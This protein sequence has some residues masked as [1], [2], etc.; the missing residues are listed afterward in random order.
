MTTVD[1]TLDQWS[2]A[3]LPRSAT[4][5]GGAFRHR[6]GDGQYEVWGSGSVS[7]LAG[8]AHSIA[9]E[10]VNPVHYLQR[11]DDSRLDTTRTA[12][13]GDQE[14]LAVGKYGGAFTFEAAYERQSRG[15]DTND[16]G[17][18]QRADEQTFEGWIGYTDR[19][20][21]GFYKTWWANLN[22][23]DTWNAAGMRLETAAN[24][25]AHMVLT[26][27]WQVNSGVTLGQIGSPVCDHCAR[28][29]PALR[30]DAQLTPFIDIVGDARSVVVPELYVPMRFADG[31]RSHSMNVEPSVS[32][33]VLPQL[34][35]SVG[36]LVGTNDDNTQ[37]LG[38]FADSG[39]TRYSFARISQ[40]TR[41]VTVR[42]SYAA[43]PFLSLETYVAPFASTGTY[44][45][46]RALSD[47]PRAGT[48]DDRFVRFARPD[49]IAENFAVR[50]L[51][52]TTVLRWEYAPGS[53][54]F[55]VWANETG[56]GNTFTVKINYW[57][58]R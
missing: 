39:V 25:N 16:L 28:G 20:P 24:A 37:W 10:Q 30:S 19:R 4:V 3:Y 27:N 31:G 52:A 1:R 55:A 53:A 49:A 13:T 38:N 14:E 36:A 57:I 33:R 58:G 35:V 51:R 47:T 7:H 44:S 22:Q 8:S 15:F 23:W 17:Y 21:R 56:V 46:V 2:D 5:G 42:G 9:A 43:T 29:G 32:L 11:V 48:Y 54:L 18:L 40:R 41:T 50:Q 12:L 6:F 45:D 26:S 34:Q